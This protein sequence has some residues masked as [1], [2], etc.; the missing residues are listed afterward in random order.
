MDGFLD[1]ASEQALRNAAAPA[2]QRILED[3]KTEGLPAPVSTLLKCL[4]EHLF[5]PQLTVGKWRRKARVRDNGVPPLFGVW[6]GVQMKDYYRWRRLEIASRML[7]ATDLDPK[8]IALAVGFPSFRAFRDLYRSWIGKAPGEDR[9]RPA[10]PIDPETMRRAVRGEL[11]AEELD[12]FIEELYRRHPHARPE[13]TPRDPGTAPEIRMIVDGREY[14]RFQADQLWQRIRTLSFE[15]QKTELEGCRFHSTVLFDLLR[16]KSREEGR[17]DRERG[18]ELARLALVSLERHDEIFGGRIHDLRALG[19][20]WL[21]NARRLMLD[22]DGAEEDLAR[23]DADWSMLRVE[24]DLGI[25]AEIH[26]VK[27]VVRMCQRRYPEALESVD[28]S[29]RLAELADDSVLQAQALTVRASVNVYTERLQESAS[30]LRTATVVLKG[31]DEPFLSFMIF[32][33]QA[34]VQMRL[35]DRDSAAASLSKAACRCR[36]LDYPLGRHEVQHLEGNLSEILGDSMSA[37]AAYLEA[38]DG[39][40]RVDE[41]LLAVLVALDLAVLDSRHGRRRRS[42]DVARWSIPILQSMKLHEETVT[43]IDLLARESA[44]RRVDQRVLVEVARLLRLDPLVRLARQTKAGR[45]S[46]PS[47]LRL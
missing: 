42:L 1:R 24:K 39:F 20:A 23:A 37:E 13:S 7:A 15:D 14:D 10:P 31:E 44:A 40:L 12:P 38:L 5:D 43:A 34:N 29:V 28:E 30:D 22:F 3:A 6:F 41:P 26:L 11:T 35:G 8:K 21:A 9:G 19:W 45:A 16:K 27:S 2:L 33:N 4:P 18:V 32:L 46:R 47:C 25:S 17:K 36:R